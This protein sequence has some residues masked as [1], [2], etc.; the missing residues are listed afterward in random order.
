LS[1]SFFFP[2][3]S[4]FFFSNYF[5]VNMIWI[6]TKPCI[7][8]AEGMNAYMKKYAYKYTCIFI[9]DSLIISKFGSLFWKNWM[10]YEVCCSSSNKDYVSQ[11]RSD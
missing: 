6:S 5:Y 9:C 11:L 7:T 1:F 8:P 10:V 4:F 3:T 2:P